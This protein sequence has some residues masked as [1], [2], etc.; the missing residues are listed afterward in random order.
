MNRLLLV[1]GDP[2]IH[3]AF[4]E[5]NDDPGFRD[6][7]LPTGAT[8]GYLRR[9]WSMIHDELKDHNFTHAAVIFDPSGKNW[10]HDL[11]KDYKANRPAKDIDMVVQ[12]AMAKHIIPSL[13]IKRIEMRGY[14]ADDLIATYVR[15]NDL[16]GGE[17]VI[18]SQ[19]KD[20]YGLLRPG[21]VMYD[22]KGKKWTREEDVPAKFFVPA[23][24]VREVQALSG[25]SIDN[26]TGIRGIGAKRAAQIVEQ[27]GG[28]EEALYGWRDAPEMKLKR[29]DGTPVTLPE[30]LR[31]DADKIRL[32]YE[33]VRLDDMVPVRVPLSDLAVAPAD[34]R[35]AIAQ[36]RALGLISFAK[37]IAW[38]H[39]LRV[40]DIAPDPE[41][42]SVALD[43]LEWRNS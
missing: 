28:V 22:R 14:E 1:D 39:Y 29:A 40:E 10:R 35:L 9:L 12:L 26:I 19:D 11:S 41:M 33:L 16:A 5:S 31:D 13:G 42:L 30:V 4:K 36:L 17:T 25:D 34:A 6:D 37:R 8:A 38:K 20:L 27:F 15:L 32:A 3:A 43:M 7:G 23:R 21:V 18:V 24:L 2:L